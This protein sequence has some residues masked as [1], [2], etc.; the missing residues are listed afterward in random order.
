MLFSQDFQFDH[1]QTPVE[2]ITATPGEYVG[3][4]IQQ[5]LEL[6][7]FWQRQRL[8]ELGQLQPRGEAPDFPAQGEAPVEPAGLAPSDPA[9]RRLTLDEANERGKDE[10]LRF[11]DPP[12]EA[13]FN[14]LLDLKQAETRRAAT[15]AKSPGLAADAIG[16]AADFAASAIDPINIASAFVPIVGPARFASLTRS[17]GSVGRARLATGAIEGAV[18]TAMVEPLIYGQAQL[19]QQEF[20]LGDAFMDVV[21][22]TAL[23]SGLHWGGGFVADKY[24][25][26]R[27]NQKAR[28]TQADFDAYNAWRR[29]YTDETGASVDWRS[30]RVT[31]GETPY[32]I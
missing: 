32:I 1:R 2:E 14:Y 30:L 27:T 24:K 7:P 28:R 23:G 6:N 19:L 31:Q 11:S 18:G 13:Q 21:F 17:L 26:F 9:A 3:A 4:G 29:T 20:T 10:G 16:I 25:A 8:G 12:T 15:L 22:G 5:T